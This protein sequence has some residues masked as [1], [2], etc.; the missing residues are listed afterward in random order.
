MSSSDPQVDLRFSAA[1]LDAGPRRAIGKPSHAPAASIASA[2]DGKP[3]VR[4]NSI[5][6]DLE[7]ADG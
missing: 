5:Q 2:P 3:N 1:A 4:S 7:A 6:P